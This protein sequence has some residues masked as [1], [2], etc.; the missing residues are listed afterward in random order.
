[1][2]LRGHGNAWHCGGWQAIVVWKMR[3]TVSR[4]TAEANV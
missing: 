4:V 3:V 1:M 2:W